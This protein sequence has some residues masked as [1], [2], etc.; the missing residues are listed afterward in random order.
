[1]LADAA[2]HSER[3]SM[4][5]P[6]ERFHFY[7]PKQPNSDYK[8][9]MV[10]TYLLFQKRIRTNTRDDQIFTWKI[11]INIERDYLFYVTNYI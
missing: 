5:C 2:T 1:M 9:Y 11:N 4:E 3:Y 10:G 6:W 7:P 8:T